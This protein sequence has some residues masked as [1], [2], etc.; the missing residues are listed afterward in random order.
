VSDG[1]VGQQA[2]TS[3][4]LAC[5]WRVA[6]GE[7]SVLTLHRMGPCARKSIRARFSFLVLEWRAPRMVS[8]YCRNSSPADIVSLRETS[9]SNRHLHSCGACS[10][11]TAAVQLVNSRLT[12]NI[13]AN[14]RRFRHQIKRDDVFGT[15]RMVPGHS[16]SSISTTRTVHL[17]AYPNRASISSPFL[18]AT[19]ESY[20]RSD[21]IRRQP[22]FF[23]S[24]LGIVNYHFNKLGNFFSGQ[25][26]RI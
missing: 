11:L 20:S 5:A 8:A 14:A 24:L 19:Q 16:L 4:C 13:A 3:A 17:P 15:H 6:I 2:F 18:L 26:T 21:V 12:A 23:S 1:A 9:L 7:H 25:I 22:S 10:R